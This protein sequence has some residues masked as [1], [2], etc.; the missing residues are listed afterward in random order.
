VQDRPLTFRGPPLRSIIRVGAGASYHAVT[1]ST[2]RSILTAAYGIVRSRADPAIGWQRE[3]ARV[4]GDL[5]TA[6]STL[7]GYK[8]RPGYAIVQFSTAAAALVEGLA[9][10]SGLSEAL[11]D[12][13]R[14]TDR[15][16][17]EAEM[18]S[19]HAIAFEGLYIALFQPTDTDDLLPTFFATE[20]S[21][22]GVD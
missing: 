5:Y 17:D 8:L 11:D 10:R 9:M 1:A 12:I 2:E 4:F 18:W 13:D 14:P 7:F 20:F 16:T 6:M 22:A 15:P 21:V 3:V 19:L